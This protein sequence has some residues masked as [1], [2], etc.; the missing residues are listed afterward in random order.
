MK[1]LVCLKFCFMS[2]Q[3]MLISTGGP[4]LLHIP[5]NK[6]KRECVCVCVCVSVAIKDICLRLKGVPSSGGFCE[7]TRDQRFTGLIPEPG[8][9]ITGL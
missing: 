6:Q 2:E 7:V 8:T 5:K 3:E 9:L 1:K 4:H